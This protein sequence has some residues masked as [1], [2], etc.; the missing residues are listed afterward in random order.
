MLDELGGERETAN[1]GVT[2]Y[3][4]GLAVGSVLFSPLSEIWGRHP[5]YIVSLIIFTATII[6]CALGTSLAEILVL[7]FFWYQLHSLS[8]KLVLTMHCSA[9]AGAVMLSNGPSTVSDVVDEEHRPLAFSI[10][11]IAPINAPVIGP[12]VGGF[13]TRSLGWRWT[14]WLAVICGGISLVM[15]S[16]IRETYPPSILRKKAAQRRKQTGDTRWWSRYDE[17]LHITD[18]LRRGISRPFIMTFTEPVLFIWAL[19]MGT[20]YGIYYLFFVAY[21]I[22]FTQDRG[23]SADVSG[24]AFMG[25][26]IGILSAIAMEPLLR[27]RTNRQKKDP[28]IGRPFPEASVFAVCIASILMPLGV[29]WFA[30]TCVPASIHWVWSLLAGVP[31]GCGNTLVMNYMQN[32]IAGCYGIYTASAFAGNTFVRR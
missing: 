1:L 12:L 9:L 20:T 2:T 17:S 21:P 18:M 23:W 5:V 15:M 6:P 8:Q 13:V 30:W 14:N 29:L 28:V 16:C 31:Y 19:Y 25:I 7:R 26:C 11:A 24:L 10:W 32:H 4:L 3:L 22:V 27:R